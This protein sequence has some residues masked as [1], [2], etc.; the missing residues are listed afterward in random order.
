MTGLHDHDYVAAHT[1]D[2]DSYRDAV[3]PWTPERAAAETGVTA[4]E[5]VEFAHLYATQRPAAIRLGVGMQRSS[6][7]GSALRAIQCLP[8]VTGQ[9]RW[10]AGGI[11]GAVS[12]GQTNLPALSRP[13]LSPAGT[14]T[15]EHDPVGSGVD[16]RIDGPAD[17]VVVRMEQQPGRDRRR[18]AASARRAGPA[19][20]SSPSCTNS[21]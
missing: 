8:A 9:W 10:P 19:R 4:E 1:T 18:S 11:A 13:D 17:Q 12:I 20:I 6:G 3:E 16:G 5:I 7:S 21:S 14:R 15:G 2:F